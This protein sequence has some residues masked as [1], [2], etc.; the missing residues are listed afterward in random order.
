MAALLIRP[1]IH[2]SA[3]TGGLRIACLFPQT[4]YRS[5]R[6]VTATLLAENTGKKSISID[7]RQPVM[8]YKSVLTGP[9]GRPAATT[10]AFANAQSFAA[11]GSITRVF[12][13]RLAPGDVFEDLYE[14]SHWFELSRTGE[15]R[16]SIELLQWRTKTRRLVTPRT[17][18]A[19]VNALR[20]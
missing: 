15:Y 9:D 5:H 20:P 19:I 7:S 16:L 8:D 3:P 4:V 2:W 12:Q 10:V 13:T 1:V 14:V 18:F 6:R 11:S 17:P